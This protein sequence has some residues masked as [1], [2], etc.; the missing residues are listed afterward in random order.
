FIM[1]S[2][3]LAMG[4]GQHPQALNQRVLTSWNNKQAPGFAAAAP[5]TFTSIYRSQLLDDA[6]SE[7]LE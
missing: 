1:S 5:Q 4:S 3:A 2:I 6:I 7:R